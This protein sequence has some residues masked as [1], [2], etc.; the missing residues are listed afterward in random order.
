MFMPSDILKE[1]F[2]I[3]FYLTLSGLAWYVCYYLG[4]KAFNYFYPDED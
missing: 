4:T 2:L 3:G 1:I